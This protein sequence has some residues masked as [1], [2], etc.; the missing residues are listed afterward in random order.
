MVEAGFKGNFSKL[1]K[2]A[3]VR[4]S[5]PHTSYVQRKP[6]PGSIMI[7]YRKPTTKRKIFRACQ[8]KCNGTFTSAVRLTAD[9]SA[10]TVKTEDSGGIF[11][12]LTG[13]CR[14]GTSR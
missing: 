13:K 10:E 9:F 12:A 1:R 2:P 7:I 5:E 14:C 6:H 11:L 4:F 8:K 3:A